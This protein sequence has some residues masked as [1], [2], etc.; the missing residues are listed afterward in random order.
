MPS[1]TCPVEVGVSRT[2]RPAALATWLGLTL[3]VVLCLNTLGGWVRLSGSGL[4]IPQWPILVRADGSRTLLPALTD[5]DWQAAHQA[6]TSDQQRLQRLVAAG[7]LSVSDLGRQPQDLARLAAAGLAHH[8]ISPA[9]AEALFG[10]PDTA[11][12]AENFE[13]DA[14]AL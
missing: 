7:A 10:S 11:A 6:F 14:D 5:S 3:I 12:A 9:I 2:I 4:A 13:R 1:A 8:T